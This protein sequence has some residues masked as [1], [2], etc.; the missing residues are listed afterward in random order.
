MKRI[1]GVMVVFLLVLGAF[2][3]TA[4]ASSRT[5][6]VAVDNGEMTIRDVVKETQVKVEHIGRWGN[7]EPE[8]LVGTL[9]WLPISGT[10]I[11]LPHNSI[12]P[13]I[14]GFSEGEELALTTYIY[15]LDD[16]TYFTEGWGGWTFSKL[17][18]GRVRIVISPWMPTDWTP[19]GTTAFSFI[20]GI[21]F[22]YT[23]ETPQ[24]ERPASTRKL[25]FTGWNEW[26]DGHGVDYEI[27]NSTNVADTSRYVLVLFGLL[28]TEVHSLNTS[29]ISANGVFYGSF[30]TQRYGSGVVDSGGS[31][32]LVEFSS[33]AERQNFLNSVPWQDR[34][35]RDP[36]RGYE[37]SY[38][39]NAAW[40]RSTFGII[41]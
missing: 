29:N 7:D 32:I 4:V 23:D 33:E 28:Y 21:Y 36:W 14:Y 9:Y 13:D 19:N 35:P 3:G 11:I 27:R 22:T 38:T 12:A 10:E 20:K 24:A 30:H 34:N 31:A 17:P 39:H 15:L 37:V 40:L 1:V 16:G 26:D 6:V 25:S 5:V 18:D 8:T 41:V 2:G